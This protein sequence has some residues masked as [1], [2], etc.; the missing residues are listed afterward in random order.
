MEN[1]LKIIYD[2]SF[3]NK[4]I[5]INDIDKILELLINE[6]QLNNYILNIDVQPIRSNN[7]ASYSNYSKK[8]TIYSNT[9][10]L[11]LKNIESNILNISNFEKT[12]YKNLSLVQVI[13]HEIEHANQ[14][15]ISYIENTL[16]AFIIRMAYT[17]DN[18]Y[19]ESLYE[20]SPQERL[21][22]IKSYREVISLTSYIKNKLDK[23][24]LILEM[25][26]LQR[27][28]RG[29]HYSQ[30]KV[31]SPL[32]TFFKQGKKEFVLQSFDWYRKDSLDMVYTQ[33]N[34]EERFNYGLPISLDEY[35]NSM[36]N[37]V[38]SLNDNFNN[39]TNFK[40]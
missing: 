11:M 24:P 36:G 40:R 13:L 34:L 38:L 16:E 14:E 30:G 6:K 31:I 37:L 9:I 8:I 12:L 7:L 3:N 5:D 10:E 21:A 35:S 4:I 28:L 27:F 2:K 32:I 20:Y 29:Y 19:F 23:L 26:K 18:S 33:Y 22:E 15:K 17:V 1:I 39:R 25:D